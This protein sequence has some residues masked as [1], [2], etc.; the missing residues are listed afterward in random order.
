[1]F[2]TRFN[3]AF[4]NAASFALGLSASTFISSCCLASMCNASTDDNLRVIVAST[5]TEKI[6]AVKKAF[7][8][9]FEDESN[10]VV[11]GIKS[12][13]SIFHGQPWGLQHTFEGARARIMDVKCKLLDAQTNLSAC[14]KNKFDGEYD[15]IVSVENG[16]ETLMTHAHTHGFDFALVIV[17]NVE[18]RENKVAIS[19]GRPYPIE[20]VQ[21]MTKSGVTRKE[22]GKFCAK[23]YKT[24]PLPITREQQI[25]EATQMALAQFK[26]N[27]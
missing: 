20:A 5:N 12:S 14:K 9:E 26:F 21:T 27:K 16:V 1:M 2:A 18:T 11:T 7:E 17:E 23:Y 4:L 22:I 15:Y 24:H 19:Q 6:N 3:T 8:A 10:I 25:F 13:S